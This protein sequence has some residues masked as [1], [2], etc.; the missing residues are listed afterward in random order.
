M[1][2]EK[3]ED[4][5]CCWKLVSDLL[6][7]LF[8]QSQE[9]RQAVNL[10]TQMERVIRSPQKPG[11]FKPVGLVSSISNCF[12]LKEDFYGRKHLREKKGNRSAS[13]LS[14]DCLSLILPLLMWGK[15]STIH[16]N[17]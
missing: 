10:E 11:L 15:R 3:D 9:Q 1:K 8:S 17:P 5:Y 2:V 12:V 14:E 7:S 4:S 16:N 13:S 6:K